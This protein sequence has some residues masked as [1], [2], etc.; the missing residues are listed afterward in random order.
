M[1]LDW[2]STEPN[3]DRWKGKHGTR[4]TKAL[5]SA[6]ILTYLR[7]KGHCYQPNAER[8]PSQN[9]CIGNILQ[10]GL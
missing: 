2:L 1:L 8:H 4:E 6:K 7:E 5:L 3:Y 10:A 9:L